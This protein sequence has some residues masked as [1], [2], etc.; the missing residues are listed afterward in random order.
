[1]LLSSIRVLLLR[2]HFIHSILTQM[3]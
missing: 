2:S 3:L 1:L